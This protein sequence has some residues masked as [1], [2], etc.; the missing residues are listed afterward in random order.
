MA[1]GGCGVNVGLSFWEQLAERKAKQSPDSH[2]VYYERVYDIN[3]NGKEKPRALF[4]DTDINSNIRA[5]S[6]KVG[7][8][9]NLIFGYGSSC[10]NLYPTGR[11][12]VGY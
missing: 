8:D 7:F 3:N 10:N 5:S 6:N 12:G 11:H 9:T 4:I 1:V 2:K